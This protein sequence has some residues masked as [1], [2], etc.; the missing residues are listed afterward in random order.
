LRTRVD[1]ETTTGLALTFALFALVAAGV[2]LGVFM[3]MI[4]SR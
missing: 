1:P 2:V 4:R 3:L